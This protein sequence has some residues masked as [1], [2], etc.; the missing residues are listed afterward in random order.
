MYSKDFEGCVQG[1]LQNTI[2]ASTREYGENYDI[3][4]NLSCV[5]ET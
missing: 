4:K 3:M 1:L 5:T 2:S